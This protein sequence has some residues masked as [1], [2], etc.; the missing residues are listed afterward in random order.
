MAAAA[1]EPTGAAF[2]ELTTSIEVDRASCLNERPGFTV[3]NLFIADPGVVLKS[4][5]DDELLISLPFTGDVHLRF[6]E[7]E[8]PPGTRSVEG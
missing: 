4:D 1:T 3:R 7:I 6:V 5:D 2:Q 8:C